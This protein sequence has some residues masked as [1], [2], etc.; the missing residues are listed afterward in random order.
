VDNLF[1]KYFKSPTLGSGSPMGL[2][3]GI[4]DQAS[5]IFRSTDWNDDHIPDNVGISYDPQLA[6]WSYDGDSISG[7][8]DLS[9]VQLDTM[10]A[11]L[12]KIDFS[13]CCLGIAFTMKAFPEIMHA[14]SS[15]SM[16]QPSCSELVSHSCRLAKL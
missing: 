4:I 11:S 2:L 14:K 16:F 15:R 5:W 8:E 13:D 1:L 10:F 3:G 6:I 7:T 9:P 12:S